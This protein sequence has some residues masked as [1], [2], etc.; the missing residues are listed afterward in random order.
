V[1]LAA[2]LALG[3]DI[4]ILDEPTAE[5]DE[6]GTAGIVSVLLDLKAHGKTI[7]LTEHK[8]SH[9]RDLVDRLV[10]MEGGEV[11]GDRATVIPRR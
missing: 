1:A 7:L 8:Y 11:P 3:T 10:V 2:A 5:L 6:E 4:V 9:F